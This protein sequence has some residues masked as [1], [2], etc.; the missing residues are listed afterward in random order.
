MRGVNEIEENRKILAALTAVTLCVGALPAVQV[1]FAAGVHC[2]KC[3]IRRWVDLPT[4]ND[5]TE[6]AI[7]GCDDDVTIA[8][9][10]SEIEGKPVTKI[11]SYAFSSKIQAGESHNT[12]QRDFRENG[13][14][15]GCSHLR[16]VTMANSVQTMGTAVFANCSELKEVTLS[17][18]LTE[19]KGSTFDSCNNLTEIV[20][21]DSVTAIGNNAFSS[22]PD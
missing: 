12:G 14:F 3:G 20:I 4:I 7:T 15:N 17:E 18:S 5:G 6:V 11:S 1:A 16:I 2:G 10:P 21:P 19:I 13:A 22:C 9:I 8:T